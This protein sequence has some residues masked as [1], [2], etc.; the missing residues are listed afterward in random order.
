MLFRSG[1]ALVYGAS[2]GTTRALLQQQTPEF[3]KE[4]GYIIYLENR[5]PVQRNPDGSEQ[6]RLV[7][8]Y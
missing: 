5:A 1:G 4:S 6:F 8:G 2:S 3:I 7:L